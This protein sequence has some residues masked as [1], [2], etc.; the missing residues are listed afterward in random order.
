MNVGRR[1][2]EW[3]SLSLPWHKFNSY[4]CLWKKSH[5]NSYLDYLSFGIPFVIWSIYHLEYHLS[6]NLSQT[7]SQSRLQYKICDMLRTT[8]RM[9][10]KKKYELY[11]ITC[12][13]LL[14]IE[15]YFKF[16]KNH[17]NHEINKY[18]ADKACFL[19]QWR[20]PK[21]NNTITWG[22]ERPWTVE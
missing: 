8:Y 7:H 13:H 20:M 19:G 10:F 4:I 18:K 12:H 5:S 6:R 16:Q 15:G 2:S 21:I 3:L 22:I 11:D 17:L 14:S 9:S 1:L